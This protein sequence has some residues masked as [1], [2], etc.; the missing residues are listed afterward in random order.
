[1][2]EV[3]N[4]VFS[5]QR[6]DCSEASGRKRSIHKHVVWHTDTIDDSL[7]RPKAQR[8]WDRQPLRDQ[9]HHYRGSSMEG[10]VQ[11]PSTGEKET[12]KILQTIYTNGK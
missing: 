8:H 7:R 1:M 9:G 10:H 12:K 5:T 4:V 6:A 2:R 3:N 11:G